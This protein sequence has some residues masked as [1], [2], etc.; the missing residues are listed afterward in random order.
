[1]LAIVAFLSDIVY[2]IQKLFNDLLAKVG[3]EKQ[4]EDEELKS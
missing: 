1:M 2:F 3:G 4:P